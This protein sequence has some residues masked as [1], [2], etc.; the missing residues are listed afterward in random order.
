[1]KKVEKIY[2]VRVPGVEADLQ[3][4][5]VFVRFE[6]WRKAS[7]LHEAPI[8]GL[9]RPFKITWSGLPYI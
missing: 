2:L 1:M 3:E 4:Q 7:V 8:N 5:G 9:Q 6:G